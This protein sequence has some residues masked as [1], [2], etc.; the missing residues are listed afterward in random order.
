KG[1][2]SDAPHPGGADAEE[3]CDRSEEHGAA[4]AGGALPRESRRARERHE[5]GLGA[6]GAPVRPSRE[7]ETLVIV[8][9]MRLPD[10]LAAEEP[11]EKRCRRVEDERREAE[12]GHRGVEGA[13]GR[14]CEAEAP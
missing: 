6:Q 8:A 13:C 7:D 4:G 9:A 12:E 10:A 5:D 14:A 11:L 1:P 2:K 3:G